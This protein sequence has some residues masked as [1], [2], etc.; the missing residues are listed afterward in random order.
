V[1][2]ELPADLDAAIAAFVSY[3]NYRRY[4]KALGNVTP[5]DVLK[6]RRQ[7]ILQR[8]KEVQAQT[9]EKRRCYNRALRELTKPPPIT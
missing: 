4:H 1:P 5:S 9:I 8:R 6:G 7:E 3:Y 2:Y